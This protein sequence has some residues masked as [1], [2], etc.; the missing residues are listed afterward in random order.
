[1]LLLCAWGRQ[2]LS[3]QRIDRPPTLLNQ[4]YSKELIDHLLIVV[5]LCCPGSI[6]QVYIT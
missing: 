3:E 1:M 2:H 6:N 4:S 5:D